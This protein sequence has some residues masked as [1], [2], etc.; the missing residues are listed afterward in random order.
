MPSTEAVAPDNLP[1]DKAGGAQSCANY[2]RQTTRPFSF[3]ALG[4]LCSIGYKR[5]RKAACISGFIA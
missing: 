5:S 1:N 4:Q 3:K 2:E